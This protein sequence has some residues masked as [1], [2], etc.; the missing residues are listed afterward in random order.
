MTFDMKSKQVERSQ[1]YIGIDDNGYD[2]SKLK[3]KKIKRS[4]VEVGCKVLFIDF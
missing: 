2:I 3:I 1:F 4:W